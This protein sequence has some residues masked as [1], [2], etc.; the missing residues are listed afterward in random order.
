MLDVRRRGPGPGE[1]T[2]LLVFEDEGRPTA[3][4]GKA[5]AEV[6]EG[7]LVNTDDIDRSMTT[8]CTRDTGSHRDA[9]L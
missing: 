1:E 7:D 3:M 8:H 4:G 2:W 5:E 6:E 9:E